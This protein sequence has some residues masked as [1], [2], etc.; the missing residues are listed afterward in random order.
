MDACNKNKNTQ[1]QCGCWQS[2]ILHQ[3]RALS[4]QQKTENFSVIWQFF[5]VNS[6]RIYKLCSYKKITE[7]LPASSTKKSVH[8][9]FP[10]YKKTLYGI[11]CAFRKQDFSLVLLIAGLSPVSL[12][13]MAQVNSPLVLKGKFFSQAS[14]SLQTLNFLIP[15]QE[16]AFEI[17]YKAHDKLPPSSYQKWLTIPNQD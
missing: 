5:F 4:Y 6:H 9:F 16:G 17:M 7:I 11:Y 2:I 15:N 10:F 1:Q 14:T 12:F 13:L 8:N 3:S